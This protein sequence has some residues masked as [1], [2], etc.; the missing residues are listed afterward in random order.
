MAQRKGKGTGRGPGGNPSIRWLTL[1][2]A[3]GVLAAGLGIVLS[4]RGAAPGPAQGPGT[5]IRT[6]NAEVEGTAAGPA[7]APLT[8]EVYSDFQCIHCK[9]AAEKTLPPLMKDYVE[10]GKVRVVYRFFPILGSESREAAT[11]AFCAAEQNRFWPYHDLLF[12]SQKGIQS[13]AF[14]R[15]NL[16][17][18][19]EQV[20][21]DV[22]AWEACLGQPKTQERIEAD[23]ASGRSYGVEGTPTFILLPRDGVPHKAVGA[24]PY[25]DLKP[26]LDQLLGGSQ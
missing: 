9:T 16:K 3:F 17:R 24:V 26:F 11:A 20:G 2:V 22:A 1:A 13:G 6:I 15:G 12:A 19:A 25:G 14:S 5:Q 23:L 18:I 21:L 4:Q 7:D 8:I 10:T